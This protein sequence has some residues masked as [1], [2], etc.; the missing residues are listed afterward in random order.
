MLNLRESK[1]LKVIAIA[2]L[3]SFLPTQSSWAGRGRRGGNTSGDLIVSAIGGASGPLTAVVFNVN[4]YVMLIT[5]GTRYA[6]IEAGCDP[7]TTMLVT[8]AVSAGADSRFAGEGLLSDAMIKAV[9]KRIVAAE[10][11][12]E[13]SRSE[14]DRWYAGMVGSLAGYATG[15]GI[16]GAY[17]NEDGF[18]AYMEQLPE[19][20][21]R[22]LVSGG[23]SSLIRYKLLPSLLGERSMALQ[24]YGHDVASLGGNL[25][26]EATEEFGI[27]PE[28]TTYR[29]VAKYDEP[30]GDKFIYHPEE[31]REA[32]DLEVAEFERYGT[33]TLYSLST[34]ENGAAVI[35]K[36]VFDKEKGDIHFF[37]SA[38][39]KFTAQVKNW[40]KKGYKCIADPRTGR[41]LVLSISKYDPRP[42][43]A[44]QDQGRVVE[45]RDDKGNIKYVPQ[46]SVKPKRGETITLKYYKVPFSDE[47]KDTE[48]SWDGVAR[49]RHEQEEYPGK[50]VIPVGAEE[51]RPSPYQQNPIGGDQK[52]KDPTP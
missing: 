26:T 9:V 50:V 10:V 12:Y 13:L 43:L 19:S 34:S 51:T 28:R 25:A 17:G 2:V 38:S 4:P 30:T 11:T 33:N 49:Y 37:E 39:P 23:I 40:E 42:R 1:C 3:L 21:A 45:A 44:W 29:V 36:R 8:A 14:G 7:Q 16:E 22:I 47:V 48:V 27:L 18:N 52:P 41:V 46:R 20:A 6:L 35:N 24:F 15:M 32:T 31:R 5:S